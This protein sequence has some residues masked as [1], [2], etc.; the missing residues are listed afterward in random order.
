MCSSMTEL[1]SLLCLLRNKFTVLII[2]TS[3]VLVAWKHPALPLSPID[4]A[5]CFVLYVCLLFANDLTSVRSAIIICVWFYMGFR[6][7][8]VSF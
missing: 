5:G 4:K 6:S 7:L 3:Y 2:V 8:L 1:M